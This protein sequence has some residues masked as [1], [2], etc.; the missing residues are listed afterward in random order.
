[1]TNTVSGYIMELDKPTLV[2]GDRE[3]AALS[4]VLDKMNPDKKNR[5]IN[6]AMKEFGD[7]KFD[8]AST[9]VIVK[10]AGI[11]K[12]LLYHYFSSKKALFNYL[13]EY[14]MKTV[15]VP[16][17]EEV[18]LEDPDIIGRIERITRLKVRIFDEIP[19]LLSFSK[20]MYEGL[21]YTE[22]KKIIQKYNPIPVDMYYS[23]N[24][25]KTLFKEEVDVAMAIKNIQFTLERVGD[26][27]LTQQKMGIEP[28]I[29]QIIEEVEAFLAHFRKIYYK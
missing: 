26:A 18:G 14:A 28:D 19:F 9:N 11:S 8:K 7:N 17:A 22:V 24:V 6:A 20:A 23:H 3:V 27:Y 1:M 4:D 5:L 15:A 21:D 13:F 29:K 2:V 25:D 10:E 16:I 12:G